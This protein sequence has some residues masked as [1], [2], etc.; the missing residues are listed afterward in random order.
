[1]LLPLLFWI[2]LIL[3]AIGSFA[4]PSWPVAFRIGPVLVLFVI[5]GLRLFRVAL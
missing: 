3:S 2:V 5:I 4:P 1:M